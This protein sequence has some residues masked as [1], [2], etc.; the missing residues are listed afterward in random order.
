MYF[1]NR[2]LLSLLLIMNN[3]YYYYH[4]YLLLYDSKID[5]RDYLTLVAISDTGVALVPRH[6]MMKFSL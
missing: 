1:I 3:F 4:Y 5:V 6:K 2:F